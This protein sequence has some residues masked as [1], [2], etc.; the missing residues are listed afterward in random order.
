V[1][2]GAYSV[3]RQLQDAGDLV[4]AASFL[5]KED[6]RRPFA[7][8]EPG[9]CVLHRVPG[10][11]L[12][13][14]A[15]DRRPG[16]GQSF[17]PA[18]VRLAQRDGS[19]DRLATT[20]AFI[21][22]HVDDDAKEIRRQ[23]RLAA[24]VRECAKEPQEHLLRRIFDVTA[25]DETSE[26]AKHHGLMV[27]NELFEVV[28]GHVPTEIRPRST[29]RVSV[30]A[31][32]TIPGASGLILAM[33]PQ[34][35]G[36]IGIFVVVAWLSTLLVGAAYLFRR[37]QSY[38]RLKAIERGID[39]AFDPQAAADMSRRAGIVLISLG[40]GMAVADCIVVW[41]SGDVQAFV[42]LALAVVPL[43]VGIGLCVDYRLARKAMSK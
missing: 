11:L 21:L 18:P 36:T 5:M 40:L 1:Q 13:E 24:K 31:A 14:R 28:V 37:L 4:V 9:E 8:G 19:I 7:I 29:T 12:L 35:L 16:V 25:A 38:E 15:V 10:V 43:A 3:Q 33:N 26:H 41:A 27:T 39:L 23:L 42:F 20:I 6:E 22:R 32:E 34:T 17:L 2:M 30:A